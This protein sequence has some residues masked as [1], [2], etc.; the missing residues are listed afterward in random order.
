MY[1]Y[2]VPNEGRD[3]PLTSISE[4]TSSITSSAPC[5]T[6]IIEPSTTDT[7]FKGATAMLKYYTQVKI[8]KIIILKKFSSDISFQT[9]K[10][11]LLLLKYVEQS[12]FEVNFDPYL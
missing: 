11:F 10:Q 5:T 1:R 2:K 3:I 12:T 8:I 7:H 9:L 4:M 6:T